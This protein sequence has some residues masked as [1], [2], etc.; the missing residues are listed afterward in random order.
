MVPVIVTLSPIYLDTFLGSDGV[1]LIAIQKPVYNPLSHISGTVGMTVIIALGTAVLVA[2]VSGHV[3]LS[4]AN[5][6]ME[7]S[8][9][10]INKPFSY[11]QFNVD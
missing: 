4:A 5:T 2:D 9:P 1:H 11:M 8:R 10:A 6:A 3:P 7:K